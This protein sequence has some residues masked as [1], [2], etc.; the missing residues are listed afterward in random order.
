M[1]ISYTFMQLTEFYGIHT[2][3]VP[4]NFGGSDTPAPTLFRTRALHS[5][6]ILSVGFSV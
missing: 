6:Q 5:Y 3:W 1:F 4:H 2:A